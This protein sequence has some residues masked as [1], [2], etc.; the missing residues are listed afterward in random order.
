[1]TLRQY[2]VFG[3]AQVYVAEKGDS[4]HDKMVGR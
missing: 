1:M 4:Q 2:S 3:H